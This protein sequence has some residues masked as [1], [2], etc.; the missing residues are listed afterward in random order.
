MSLRPLCMWLC[1]LLSLPWCLGASLFT[2]YLLLQLH[3]LLLPP[4][5]VIL[6]PY[7]SFTILR[8]CHAFLLALDILATSS[9]FIWLLFIM[10]ASS[11]TPHLHGSF[12]V[13]KSEY[14]FPS[15]SSH[16]TLSFP[17]W[18]LNCLFIC[19]LPDHTM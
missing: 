10:Q 11:E 19:L 16:V 4:H 13:P 18:D 1:G 15:L 3:L 17:L 6:K 7:C 9:S 5:H 12:P 2:P 8:M 14:G